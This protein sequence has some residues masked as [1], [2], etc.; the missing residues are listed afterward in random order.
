MGRLPLPHVSEPVGRR[1]SPRT[2]V[3]PGPLHAAPAG[4][5]PS[6][7]AAT[8]VSPPGMAAD[9]VPREGSA[10]RPWAS[11]Q[12]GLLTPISP[13]PSVF[14]KQVGLTVATSTPSTTQV[15]LPSAGHTSPRLIPR[16]TSEAQPVIVQKRKLKLRPWSE[17]TS[18]AGAAAAACLRPPCP[19]EPRRGPALWPGALARSTAPGQ[20]GAAGRQDSRRGPSQTGN[21]CPGPRPV[22]GLRLPGGCGARGPALARAPA[23]PPQMD[24]H[25]AVAGSQR[26]PSASASRAWDVDTCP[27]MRW[28]AV[29][30][31]QGVRPSARTTP[32]HG[33]AVPSGASG[34]T[35]GARP[36]ERAR[37]Q[38]LTPAGGGLGR[39][40]QSLG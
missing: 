28:P 27:A 14:V 1:D 36:Q 24:R 3:C 13:R 2:H 4:L 21:A 35:P 7:E 26:L 16:R 12:G 40:P 15:A 33:E 39:T 17:V 19:A 32:A 30:P 25:L 6:E 11:G 38:G 34:H 9:P 37:G 23:G 22:L 18:P 31:G 5:S 29:R 8:T 20:Q 10:G